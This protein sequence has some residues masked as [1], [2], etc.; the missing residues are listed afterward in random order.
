MRRTI[1]YAVAVVATVVAVLAVMGVPGLS[2]GQGTV[3][4]GGSPSDVYALREPE[5][6]G[7][8]PGRVTVDGVSILPL[9]IELTAPSHVLVSFSFDV[10]ALASHEK[11]SLSPRLDGSSDDFQWLF[12][13]NS[14]EGA[15]GS[16]TS[17][18]PDQE[19]GTHYVDIYAEVQGPHGYPGRL[20]AS[21]ETCTLTVFVI[22]AV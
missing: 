22:P 17:V 21:L 15:P 16:V 20:D 4:H 1:P 19:V 12:F 9:Q 13:G 11:V 6:E 3:I 8:A 14:R 7:C 2:F 5:Q 18:F 10:A